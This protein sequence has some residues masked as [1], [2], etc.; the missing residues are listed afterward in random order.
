M[1]TYF[2]SPQRGEFLLL[3][4]ILI[5]AG[6]QSSSTSS[7]PENDCP[8][9]IPEAIFS[10]T[11]PQLASHSFQ[12]EGVNGLEEITFRDGRRL[13]IYQTGCQTLRQELRFTLP[14]SVPADMSIDW[15]SSA[16][17]QIRSLAALGTRFSGFTEWADQLDQH[18]DEF[19]LAEA[20]SI[21][22]GIFARIDRISGADNTTV[23][24]TL[25]NAP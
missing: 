14:T 9:G 19:R 23:I 5:L 21:S 17:A 20:I 15:V 24:V 7:K 25:S 8:Y 1:I 10:D 22:P 18:H 4:L 11:L 12:R 2:T 16:I 6:C 13:E 3:L